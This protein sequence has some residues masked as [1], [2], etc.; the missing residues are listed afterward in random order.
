MV[1]SMRKARK[2]LSPRSS[3]QKANCDASACLRTLPFHRPHRC[4]LTVIKSNTQVSALFLCTRD[5]CTGNR[6]PGF[7]PS[8][9]IGRCN[10][11]CPAKPGTCMMD[12]H[13]GLFL[14]LP[15][16]PPRLTY[17]CPLS[18]L[19]TLPCVITS[20][21]QATRMPKKNGFLSD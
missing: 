2:K 5:D 17:T 14:S 19:E 6:Y 9:R 15:R 21:I 7:L 1:M 16:N 4:A 8:Q 11:H 12:A 10:T 3:T 13:I 20:V 18:I